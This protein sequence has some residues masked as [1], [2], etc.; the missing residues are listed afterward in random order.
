LEFDQLNW[1]GH[2]AEFFAE[3]IALDR[4]AQQDL[5]TRTNVMSNMS[6]SGGV[7]IAYTTEKYYSLHIPGVANFVLEGVH[8]QVPKGFQMTWRTQ[9]PVSSKDKK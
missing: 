8:V 7:T 1:S 2:S 9:E 6:L 3:P 4:I 5:V